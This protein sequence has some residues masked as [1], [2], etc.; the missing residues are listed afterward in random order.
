MHLIKKA[1]AIAALAVERM[2]EHSH[3]D[4]ANL[5]ALLIKLVKSDVELVMYLREARIALAEE[6]APTQALSATV[7]R[8]R[9]AGKLKLVNDNLFVFHDI[10]RRDTGREADGAEGVRGERP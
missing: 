9:P 10:H 8:N 2:T 3:S 7:K 5:K 6:L 1:L 4:D